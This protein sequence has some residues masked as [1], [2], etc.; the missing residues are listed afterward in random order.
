MFFL[1]ITNASFIGTFLLLSQLYI[2]IHNPHVC[3]LI[4]NK[5]TPQIITCGYK[6]IKS[7]PT[8]IIEEQIKSKSNSDLVG[9]IRPTHSGDGLID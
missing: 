4:N 1:R 7:T 2:L 8:L 3:L 5:V 6:T 9:P